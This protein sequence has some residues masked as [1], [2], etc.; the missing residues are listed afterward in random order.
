MSAI[1]EAFRTKLLSYSTVSTIVGQRMYPDALKVNATLPAIVYYVI[2]TE[3]DHYL[4]G[5]LKSAH[6]RVQIDCY[7]STRTGASALAK[8]IRETGIDAYRGATGSY[9]FC[10]VEFD[11]G[12]EY[13]QEPP[14][15]GNQE[16]RY[17]VSFDCLVHYKEP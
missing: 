16:H 14:T 9:T 4:G 13:L 17:I 12:D 8:A 5:L 6:A 15:D 1:G 10:G 11:S 3:R 7:S 2:S